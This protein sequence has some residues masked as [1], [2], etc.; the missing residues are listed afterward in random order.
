M[1]DGLRRESS[2]VAE[3]FEDADRTMTP[4]L[5]KPLS[6]LIFIDGAINTLAPELDM[7]ATVTDVATHFAVTHGPTI[8]SQLGLAGESWE[9]DMDGI[10]AGFGVDP[11]T[12][13]RLTYAELRERRALI[14]KRLSGRR[15]S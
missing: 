15:L 2:I 1:L 3:T 4:L 11:A 5:G 8:A 10:K 9:V 13:N 6:D 7:F 12:T 14:N